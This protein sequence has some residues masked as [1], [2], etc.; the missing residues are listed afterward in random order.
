MIKTFPSKVEIVLT[1]DQNISLKMILSDDQNIFLKEIFSED[2][3]TSLKIL[4]YNDQNIFLDITLFDNQNI[5]LIL[6]DDEKSPK[7]ARE[8]IAPQGAPQL[9]SKLQPSIV[10]VYFPSI[11]LSVNLSILSSKNLHYFSY[12][13][14]QYILIIGVFHQYIL[15]LIYPS[16]SLSKKL[17]QFS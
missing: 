11:L 8:T 15:R 16:I 13:L 12:F 3:N 9:L 17:R 10:D 4:L 2:Q 5:F 14:Y 6:S 7:Q 1:Y